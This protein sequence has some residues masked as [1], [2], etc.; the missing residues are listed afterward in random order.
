[1]NGAISQHY[2]AIP[3]YELYY[4]DPP[5]LEA[6]LQQHPTTFLALNPANIEQQWATGSEA[7]R[8]ADL[9]FR[10]LREHSYLVET[11]RYPPWVLYEIRDRRQC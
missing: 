5:A 10:W 1:M 11:G 9:A 3:T 2:T 6:F 4:L 8:P 7:D